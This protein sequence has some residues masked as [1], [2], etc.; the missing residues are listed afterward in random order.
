MDNLSNYEDTGEKVEKVVI[1]GE[2]EIDF[3]SRN[4]F[5]TWLVNSD[6]TIEGWFGVTLRENSI[7]EIS[8]INNASGPV[9][10]TFSPLFKLVDQEGNKIVIGGGNGTAH[11]YAV[12]SILKGSI[13][14]LSMRIGSKDNRKV[15]DS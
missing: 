12:G 10:V 14:T 13:M 11:F 4:T 1:D 3:K 6:T 7:H 5:Q 8:I 2:N 15:S 9:T